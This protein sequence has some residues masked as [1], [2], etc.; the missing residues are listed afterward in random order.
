[1]DKPKSAIIKTTMEGIHLLIMDKFMDWKRC[2]LTLLDL[3]NMKLVVTSENGKLTKK[4][5]KKL[6]FLLKSTLQ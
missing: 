5:L 3:I 2:T 1:M 6:F 4:L